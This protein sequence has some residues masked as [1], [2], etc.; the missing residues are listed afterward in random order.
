[1]SLSRTIV[2]WIAGL[3]AITVGSL[4][5]ISLLNDKN[6]RNVCLVN[7]RQIYAAMISSG[8]ESGAKVGDRLPMETF[9]CY[10]KDNQLPEC[11]KGA[12]YVILVL[13]THP[14]CRFHGDLLSNEDHPE[15]KSLEELKGEYGGNSCKNGADVTSQHTTNELKR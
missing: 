7:Q 6:E 5:V 15:G 4:C 13:G 8:L 12:H 11:P 3:L 9:T 14:V 2:C 10:L 1:M